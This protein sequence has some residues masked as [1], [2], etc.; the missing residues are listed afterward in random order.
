LA[1]GPNAGAHLLPKAS[2]R[3]SFP[4]SAA[5]AAPDCVKSRFFENAV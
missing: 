5:G 3:A 1:R 2:A 4:L